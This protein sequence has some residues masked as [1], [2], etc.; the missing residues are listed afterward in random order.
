MKALWQSLVQLLAT[1]ETA[2]TQALFRIAVGLVIL[3]SLW[4]VAHADVVDMIWVDARHG[5]YRAL[6]HGNWLL[7]VLGGPTP[8]AVWTLISLVGFSASALLL[9]IFP[10]VAAFLALHLYGALIGINGDTSGGYDAMIKNALWLLV[11]ADSGRSLSLQCWW[12]EGRWLSQERVAAWPRYLVILQLVLMY[13]ATGLQKVSITWNPLGGYSALYWVFQDPTW[14][15]SDVSWT[16]SVYPLTQLGTALTWHWE[17]GAPLL[18]LVYY[19]RYTRGRAGRVRQLFN[20]FDLRIPFAVIGVGLHIGIL[21]TL[22]VGP[23]S[24]ISLAYYLCLW[25]PEEIEG[26]AAGGRVPPADAS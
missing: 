25:R 24:W 19:Y 11:L 23:F 15:L 12:R 22:N 21:L 26:V 17:I 8:S 3:G 5:G 7:A 13:G 2:T 20:R 6:G 1:R 16:A 14:I 18:L 10:R 9:G 4:S